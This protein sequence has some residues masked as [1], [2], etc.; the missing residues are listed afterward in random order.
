MAILNSSFL[1]PV[2]FHL[3][4]LKFYLDDR[5]LLFALKDFH[6]SKQKFHFFNSNLQILY[7][8]LIS[9]ILQ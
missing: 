3:N 4:E 1:E 7:S 6:N 8:H 5:L 2:K 9:L